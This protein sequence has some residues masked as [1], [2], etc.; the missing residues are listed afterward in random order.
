MVFIP[1]GHPDEESD[2]P[3]IF[4]GNPVIS[5]RYSLAS[6]KGDFHAATS[7]PKP[8]STAD[9]SS[10]ED[11]S[12]VCSTML[13]RPIDLEGARDDKIKEL[14]S[15]IKDQEKVITGLE[16]LLSESC[17]EVESLKFSVAKLLAAPTSFVF[18]TGLS[19]E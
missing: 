18:Y 3:A 11:G 1:A 9:L 14:E 5:K 10:K 4:L 16:K 2:S 15:I 19:V 17:A 8:L 6:T 12:G 7:I 13:T